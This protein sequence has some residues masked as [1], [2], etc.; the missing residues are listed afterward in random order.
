MDLTSLAFEVST[1]SLIWCSHV[2]EHIPDDRKAMSELFRVL[3]PGGRAI[4]L[5]PIFG[6][7][8]YEDPTITSPGERFKHF[9]QRDHVRSY[10]I[11]IADRLSDIGFKVEVLSVESVPG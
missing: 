11:D 2:L 3:Q 4:I 6:K 7:Q 9:T 5:V 10:G 8:T 1:F